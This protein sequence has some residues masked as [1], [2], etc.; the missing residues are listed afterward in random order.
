MS[1]ESPHFSSVL[2][3]KISEETG[4]QS[5]TCYHTSDHT[6]SIRQSNIKRTGSSKLSIN[7]AELKPKPS[8]LPVI[9]RNHSQLETSVALWLTT[10]VLPRF[11]KYCLD[12][13]DTSVCCWLLEDLPSSKVNATQEF[14]SETPEW[15][16][17][18]DQNPRV[19]SK[20]LMLSRADRIR[21]CHL[22]P[23]PL[24]CGG[25]LSAAAAVLSSSES[26]PSPS[27][28]WLL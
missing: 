3:T 7:S 26:T 28:M 11:Q 12:V 9:P 27:H 25:Q 2:S 5:Q 23:P 14:R 15:R 17:R 21:G 10:E 16:S 13:T 6:R 24:H 20:R 18:S 22:A 1:P 8:S 19:V 4:Q